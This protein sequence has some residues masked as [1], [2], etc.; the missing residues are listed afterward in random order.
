MEVRVLPRRA[1]LNDFVY[2]EE[3]LFQSLGLEGTAG[4]KADAWVIMPRQRALSTKLG[5]SCCVL[6]VCFTSKGIVVMANSVIVLV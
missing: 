5:P 4:M 1:H 3:C 2:P 6:G